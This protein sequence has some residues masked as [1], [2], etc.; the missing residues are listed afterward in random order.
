[1][2]T[3]AIEIKWAILFI[4]LQLI[5][6]IGER[7]AGLHD[8][9]IDKHPIVTNFFA[10][11]AIAVYVVA[12]LDKRKNSFGGKM[13]WKQ[14]FISGLIIT[15][16]VTLLTPLSQY[17]TIALITPG[18]FKNI[19]TYSVSIGKMSQEAAEAYFNMKSYILQSVIF[20]PVMGVVTSAI[21]ALFTKMK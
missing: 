16:G 7:L 19:I 10:V 4:I 14:G 1:M 9:N 6:M 18:Y 8:E 21:V 2:K 3:I 20:A 13:T 5:W 12:L 11:V 15:A 17:I